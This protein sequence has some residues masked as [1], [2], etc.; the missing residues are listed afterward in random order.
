V[1]PTADPVEPSDPVAIQ[2]EADEV[3]VGDGDG[4]GDGDE[5]AVEIG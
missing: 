2:S 3:A 4:D 1:E 5:G